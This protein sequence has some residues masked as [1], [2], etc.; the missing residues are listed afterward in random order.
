[1]EVIGHNQRVWQRLRHGGPVGRAGVH[2][3][4]QYGVLPDLAALIKPRDHVGLGPPGCLAQ[5]AVVA[6][7]VDEVGL[8]GLQLH[9]A[10]AVLP[11]RPAG[12][13]AAGLIDAQHAHRRRLGQL[14]GGS[15]DER[16]VRD[17]PA[18]Q[19]RARAADR[20]PLAHPSG[21]MPA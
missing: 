19:P 15:G 13:A 1:V 2:R 18:H 8:E 14:R 11:A 9:P 20:K 5:Q 6:G 7:E 16:G 12:L 4:D 10:L 17:R 3:H 21:D